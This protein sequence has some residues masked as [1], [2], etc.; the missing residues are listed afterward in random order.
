MRI[1][2][3]AR[4]TFFEPISCKMTLFITLNV[5]QKSDIVFPLLAAS[6]QILRH[7]C[8]ASAW[9]IGRRTGLCAGVRGR[10]AAE[11]GDQVG[12]QPRGLRALRVARGGVALSAWGVAHKR[13]SSASP[14]A[15]ATGSPFFLW[16]D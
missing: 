6:C 1:G 14:V 11:L 3:Y 10:R 4:T 9:A 12:R 2:M 7:S 5:T 15:E 13:R 8:Q 16:E